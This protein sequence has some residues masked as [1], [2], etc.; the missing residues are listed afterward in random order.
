MALHVYGMF[1]FGV[2]LDDL[3]TLLRL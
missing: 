2:D 3:H 1:G